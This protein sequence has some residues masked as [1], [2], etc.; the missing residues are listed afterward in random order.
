MKPVVQKVR[1]GDVLLGTKNLRS[2]LRTCSMLRYF[3]VLDRRH[4]PKTDA[5]S[6]LY[7]PSKQDQFVVA[8]NAH[9]RFAVWSANKNVILLFVNTGHYSARYSEVTTMDANIFAQWFV[10]TQGRSP[11][12]KSWPLHAH[13]LWASI[14][15]NAWRNPETKLRMTSGHA[16][17]HEDG[18][19]EFADGMGV[20]NI[21]RQTITH[22]VRE[23]VTR[24]VFRNLPNS[25]KQVP[26]LFSGGGYGPRLQDLPGMRSKLENM[27]RNPRL[28]SK[29][30]KQKELDFAFLMN[31]KE[32]P[33]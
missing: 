5:K 8:A 28:V 13:Y 27:M 30:K 25:K 12:V 32:N 29:A 31:V 21:D 15:M 7:T 4:G 1:V 33:L 11:A 3:R 17:H 2:Y 6:L 10:R 16:E 19:F 18:P 14:H 23:S 20:G 24:G 26:Q 22:A 9:D